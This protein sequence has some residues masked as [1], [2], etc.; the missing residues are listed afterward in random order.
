MATSISRALLIAVRADELRALGGMI[1]AF[2]D[3]RGPQPP[4]FVGAELNRCVRRLGVPRSRLRTVESSP[5][6]GSA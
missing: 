1:Q 6:P 3:R 2:D 5:M 4:V